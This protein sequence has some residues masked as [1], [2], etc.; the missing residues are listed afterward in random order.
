MNSQPLPFAEGTIVSEVA[1]KGGRLV[2]AVTDPLLQH[3][4]WFTDPDDVAG[5]NVAQISSMLGLPIDFPV[6]QMIAV[7]FPQ[8]TK[9]QIGTAA[10]GF[11]QAG[12]GCLIKVLDC[13]PLVSEE[14]HFARSP[15]GRH[16]LVH[17]HSQEVRMSVYLGRMTLV[18]D[19]SVVV[20]SFPEL[21]AFNDP[22]GKCTAWSSDSRYFAVR[23]FAFSGFGH[24][25]YDTVTARCALI[26]GWRGVASFD[27]PR[28]AISQEGLERKVA[29]I[30]TVGISD[31]VFHDFEKFEKVA[32]NALTD[33]NTDSHGIP[34][35]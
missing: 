12:G 5:K 25:I 20:R 22:L 2:R 31:L 28:L 17:S 21:F 1:L 9:V 27:G 16:A 29:T 34:N 8:G 15:D 33:S 6:K 23:V 4:V 19:K 13:A 14:N 3:G 24:F 30:F 26:S 35:G 11:G 7:D 32:A 10:G 18:N